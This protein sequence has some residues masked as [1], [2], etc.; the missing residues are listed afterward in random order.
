MTLTPHQRILPLLLISVLILL[1]TIFPACSQDGEAE[2]SAVVV[3]CPIP[4]GSAYGQNGERG[5]MLAAEEINGAGGI[6][7]N[8]KPFP[9]ELEIVDTRDLEP[10]VPTSEVLLAIEKLILQKKVDVIAGGPCMSEAGIAAM[11]VC[12]RYGTVQLASIGCYT[13]T[14][15]QEKFAGDPQKY[16]HSFR[17]SGSV[18]WYIQEAVDLLN[19][20]KKQFGF[21]KIFIMIED[22]LMCRKAAEILEK[23]AV[24]SGWQVVGHDRHPIAAT[25]FSVALSECKESGAQVLFI[26]GYAPESSILLRQWA[27]MKIPAIPFG[28]ICAA[29]DPAFWK[30]TNG[31]CA[32]TMV[33]LAE[34]GNVPSQVT[35]WADRFYKAFE[36]RWGVPPRSTGCVS[37]YESLY[38]LKDAVERAGTLERDA[39]IKSLEETALPCVRGTVRFNENHQIVQGND[40]KTTSLGTWIQWQDGERVGVWPPAA[41]TG[42]I[43]TPPWLN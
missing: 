16:R 19:D 34:A 8:G 39:L 32:Y 22:S 38:V 21:N 25:D 40:P 42:E 2:K 31:K 6:S 12:A 18:A 11:D 7:L 26:W 17:V 30:A 27:D 43:K 13:P 14:W 20:M 10:G 36:E 33:A 1:S 24:K 37:A 3:G 5:I 41:A 9:V 35:P 28:F 29:E 15:D 4:R 23:R